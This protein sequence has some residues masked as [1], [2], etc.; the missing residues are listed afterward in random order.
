MT[1]L[2]TAE[3]LTAMTGIFPSRAPSEIELRGAA[4]YDERIR[5]RL[6]R[7]LEAKD[8]EPIKWHRP[9][10]QESL[11]KRLAEPIDEAVLAEI[12]E[13]A[14]EMN[15]DVA[16]AVQWPMVVKAARDYILGR[17][18]VFRDNSL[19]L[20]T[21]ELAPD[22]YGDVWHLCR[23]L[24]D[25]ET[26]FDD[27]DSLLLLPAQVDAF[28]AVYPSLLETTR[29]LTAL[30]IQPYVEVQG[31]IK[32][33]RWLSGDREEQLR[34]LLQRPGDVPIQADSEAQQQEAQQQPAPR[35]SDTA[36]ENAKG[37]LRT[38]MENIAEQRTEIG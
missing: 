2:V 32:P 4:N 7:F 34:V 29:Q 10:S 36:R 26:L 28:A 25:P 30:L 6:V 18:P 13:W 12:N 15:I 37:D 5:R 17:W 1:N 22:E 16:V 31:L 8:P 23:T 35:K 20:S 33:K 9:P 11:W 14:M 38:P 24:H 21:Y 3:N 19:G 27:L